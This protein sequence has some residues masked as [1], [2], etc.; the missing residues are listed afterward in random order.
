MVREFES[1][2]FR[3]INNTMKIFNISLHR[4]GT[5][6][7]SHLMET[8]VSSLHFVPEGWEIPDT[9]NE[10]WEKYKQDLIPNFRNG[11]SHTEW[12]K[13][14]MAFHSSV[15]GNAPGEIAG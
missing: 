9:E 7:F 13:I 15:Q 5:T 12:V 10:L 8:K 1:H 14:S 3:Q 6:S 11:L 2:R 4:T